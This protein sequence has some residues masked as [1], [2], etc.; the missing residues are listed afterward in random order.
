VSS[1]SSALPYQRSSSVAWLST[2]EQ[3]PGLERRITLSVASRGDRASRIPRAVHSIWSGRKRVAG[4]P[5][6]SGTAL[7][8]H[9]NER[10]AGLSIGSRARIG[11]K[12]A[13]ADWQQRD[14]TPHR[15]PTTRRHSASHPWDARLGWPFRSAPAGLR[16]RREHSPCRY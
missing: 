9:T 10:L 4:K 2:P 3:L 6:N 15:T 14:R 12:V 1:L 11:S 5:Q 16:R 8:F 13:A 7:A